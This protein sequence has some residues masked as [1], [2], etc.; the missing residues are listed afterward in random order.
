M[1]V[2]LG[3][4]RPYQTSAVGWPLPCCLE[5]RV[6]PSEL[7]GGCCL[8]KQP[9][10]N[11]SSSWRPE[12]RPQDRK[13]TLPEAASLESTTEQPLVPTVCCLFTQGFPHSTAEETAVR[14]GEHTRP[15]WCSVEPSG[16]YTAAAASDPCACTVLLAP[17]PCKEQAWRLLAP[18]G[19][20]T[21]ACSPRSGLQWF[22]LL[23][24]HSFDSFL[25]CGW[26]ETAL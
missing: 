13:W 14:K 16:Y 19:E 26:W 10:R 12:H 24:L 21:A 6:F 8:K 1:Q 22:G 25:P 23:P 3:R 9:H 5:A 17:G 4:H 15:M 7:E 20:A 18:T 2:E 11:N